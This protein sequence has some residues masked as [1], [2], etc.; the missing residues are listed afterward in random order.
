MNL[1]LNKFSML[2]LTTKWGCINLLMI[3][4]IWNR[5]ALPI[6]WELLP[7]Q[8]NSNFESQTAAI[9]KIIRLFKD[10]KVVLLETE[11]FVQSN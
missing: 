10:Y 11:N 6:Y 3:S 2:P 1:N 4:L 8:G 5:R 9:T 7:K